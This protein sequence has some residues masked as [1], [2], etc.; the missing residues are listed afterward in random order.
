MNE[1]VKE[2]DKMPVG[3]NR[4]KFAS[5]TGVSDFS[6]QHLKRKLVPALQKAAATHEREALAQRRTMSCFEEQNT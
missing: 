1:V 5:L 4:D 3:L 6:W 2:V